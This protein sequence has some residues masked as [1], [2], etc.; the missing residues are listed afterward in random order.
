GLA[1]FGIDGDDRAIAGDAI[2]HAVGRPH[3]DAE[4][5]AGALDIDLR[6]HF[7]RRRVDGHDR[8][9]VDEADDP[10]RR[11][12]AARTK[13][14]RG[15]RTREREYFE[16]SK[17][18]VAPLK[19][20]RVCRSGTVPRADA[21]SYAGKRAR[22]RPAGGF[23]LRGSHVTVRIWRADPWL[24]RRQRSAVNAMRRNSCYGTPREKRIRPGP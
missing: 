5:R 7:A 20:I 23:L 4:K 11:L 8:L 9:A 2:K 12:S 19:K 17:H 22:M 21:G 1:G 16:L 14:R 24:P 6:R 18:H 10:T 13:A 15:K 3:V